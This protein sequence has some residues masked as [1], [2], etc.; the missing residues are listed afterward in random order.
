MKVYKK[1]INY[2]VI[3]LDVII[4]P[5][6]GALIVNSLLM[7][8]YYTILS[9]FSFKNSLIFVIFFMGMIPFIVYV[10][11]LNLKSSGYSFDLDDNNFWKDIGDK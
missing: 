2:M 3:F 4:Y 1:V 11:F 8:V 5:L 10:G 7:S 6:I 9:D